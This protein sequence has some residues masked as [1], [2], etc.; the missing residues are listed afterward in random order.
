MECREDKVVVQ[1]EK[2]NVFAL[3]FVEDEEDGK[4]I[5]R[6]VPV[7]VCYALTIHKS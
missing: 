5:E 4:V 6:Y 2:M 1:D 3:G 7:Q